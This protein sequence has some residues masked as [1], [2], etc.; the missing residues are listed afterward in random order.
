MLNYSSM[1]QLITEIEREMDRKDIGAAYA[2]A[3]HAARLA[4]GRLR[5]FY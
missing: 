1:V 3:L 4:L 5:A 2:I